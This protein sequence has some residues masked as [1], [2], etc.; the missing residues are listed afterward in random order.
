MRFA[1]ACVTAEHTSRN[2]CSPRFDV[3]PAFVTP[4]IDR[5]T[6]HVFDHQI[7]A[8][9]RGDAGVEQPRDARMLQPSEDQRL[10]QE[11]FAQR[12]AAE[13]GVQRLDRD[14]AL[15]EAVVATGQ[16]HF[17]HAACADPGFNSIGAELRAGR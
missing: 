15:V 4:G 11:T 8:A 3:E 9:V 7:H 12:A 16:P 17:A 2:N 14:L 1:C 5:R 6:A 13:I 10:A